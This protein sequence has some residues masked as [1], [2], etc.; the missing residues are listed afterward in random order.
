MR[1][2]A[3]RCNLCRAEMRIVLVE[4]D[5]GMKAVGYE[6]QTLECLG[7]QKTER[8]LAFSI[9]TSSVA[10]WRAV[11]AVDAVV[12]TSLSKIYETLTTGAPRSVSL[13]RDY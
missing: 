3:M 6:H 1:K 7:C 12:P 2:G 4:Q 11:T 13:A 5:Y 9:D 10:D 8:R